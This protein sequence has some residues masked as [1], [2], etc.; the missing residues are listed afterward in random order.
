MSN[1]IQW[2]SSP[3]VR[4]VAPSVARR[5]GPRSNIARR[6][7]ARLYGS[8]K[9]CDPRIEPSSVHPPVYRTALDHG[10][11]QLRDR[12]VWSGIC[13]QGALPGVA[14]SLPNLAAHVV[15]AGGC[16]YQSGETLRIVPFETQDG[17]L[18]ICVPGLF[19]HVH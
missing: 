7:G 18:R 10:I 3:T 16:R 1:V 6:R 11:Y 2:T 5:F 13:W 4:S 9:A 19:Q 17:G 15:A 12:L 8:A 14:Q